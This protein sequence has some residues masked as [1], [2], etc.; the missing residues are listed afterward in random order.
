MD[1]CQ[2]EALK[3]KNCNVLVGSFQF[4]ESTSLQ[5]ATTQQLSFLQKIRRVT[6]FVYIERSSFDAF[7]FLSNL[8]AIDGQGVASTQ[9]VLRVS[10][11]Y[12]TRFLGLSSL[13]HLGAGRVLFANNFFMCLQDTIDYDRWVFLD[14]ASA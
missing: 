3:A 1:N 11:N 6:E 9:Y 7:S 14:I 8:A 13:R 12:I 5:Y 10:F 4:T 2:L